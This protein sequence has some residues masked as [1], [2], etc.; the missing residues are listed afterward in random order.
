MIVKMIDA[1]PLPMECYR[2][3]LEH[4]M[5]VSGYEDRAIEEPFII[6]MMVE[7]D[8]PKAICVNEVIW[9][10]TEELKRRYKDG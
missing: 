2:L 7:R 6:E 1:R 8:T 5:V 10:L 4:R 9:K 3:T